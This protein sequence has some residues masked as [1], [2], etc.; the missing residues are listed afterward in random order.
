MKTNKKPK[1]ITL[2]LSL[3]HEKGFRTGKEQGYKEKYSEVDAHI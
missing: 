3:K 1:Q 2:F